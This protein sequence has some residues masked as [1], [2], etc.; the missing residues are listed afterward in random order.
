MALKL[1]LYDIVKGPVLTDKAYKQYKKLNK[2][3]LDV[4]PQ[5]NKPQIAQA[6]EKLFNVKVSAV[7]VVVRKGKNK[8]NR[9]K[10]ST[11]QDPVKKRA[12]VT[13]APGHT[14]D[15]LGQGTV[16]ADATTEAAG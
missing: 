1:T 5:A 10:R 4:H 13:L 7:R 15:L 8:F 3:V 16:Q 12:Y 6:L 14:L 9:S 2:L 11:T